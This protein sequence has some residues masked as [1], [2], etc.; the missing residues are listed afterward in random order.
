MHVGSSDSRC[1]GFLCCAVVAYAVPCGSQSD[2]WV[3]AAVQYAVGA[4]VALYFVSFSAATWPR[5]IVAL[6]TGAISGRIFWAPVA[7]LIDHTFIPSYAAP[8]REQGLRTGGRSLLLA[9]SL[10]RW[11]AGLL[12]CWLDRSK[13]KLCAATDRLR[14][15]LVPP[16]RLSYPCLLL[17]HLQMCTA[18]CAGCSPQPWA[19]SYSTTSSSV[20]G[21]VGGWVGA[22]RRWVGGQRAQQLNTTAALPAVVALQQARDGRCA[23]TPWDAPLGALNPQCGRHP[24]NRRR[25]SLGAGLVGMEVALVVLARSTPA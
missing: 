1:C 14:R 10:A 19:R 24:C 22:V 5:V 23:S 6:V 13:T 2:G 9:G 7:F 11:L 21:R 15:S 20:G 4:F 12:A 17:A 8:L 16:A 18:P 3:R 25:S